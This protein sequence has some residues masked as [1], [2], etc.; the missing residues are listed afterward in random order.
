MSKYYFTTPIYYVNGRPHIGHAYSTIVADVIRRFRRMQGR[1]ASFLTGTD[2]HG[3]KIERAAQAAGVSVR[4]F[5]DANSGTFRSLWDEMG[6]QYS[7][8]VRTTEERHA[9]AVQTLF[10]AAEKNGYIYKGAYSGAYCVY[11]ELYVTER[12]PGD[13]CPE[14]GRPTEHVTEDN[15]YFKLSAFEDKL[16]KLYAE[17]PD[18]IRPESRR[19]EV[20]SFVRSGLHDL[21]ISRT[22]IKWGI[23]LPADDR[24]VFY[25]WWDA[26]ISYISGIGYAQGGEEEKRFRE[27]W[28]A[29]LHLVGKEIVR[30]HAVY[31]P[32]FL[33]AA[34]LELPRGIFAHGW[35]LFEQ[36]KMSKSR[37]NVVR[38]GPILHVIGADGL[39]Y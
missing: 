4:D 32:A 14:C 20:T 36:D 15:Y 25:V 12:Q 8:F 19:N 13:L 26:L 38:P 39:R 31:W 16:L 27:L 37:G 29:D 2:E 7:Y 28:P 34:G 17:R 30:F 1:D 23:P 35:L 22:T 6:L 10:R 21:S 18:F 3:Q 33:M 9:R 11:D 24:H 5:T